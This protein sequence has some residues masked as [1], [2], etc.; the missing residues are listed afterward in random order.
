M[1]PIPW[2]RNGSD[3]KHILKLYIQSSPLVSDWKAFK[4]AN[5]NMIWSNNNPTGK[6]KAHNLRHNLKAVI[7]RYDKHVDPSD[8]YDG[9]SQ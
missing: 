9:A 2:N 1:L 6:Y 8:D 5:A 3:A 7:D 4:E